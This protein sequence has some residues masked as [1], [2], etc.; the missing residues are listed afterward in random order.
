MH[1]GNGDRLNDAWLACFVARWICALCEGTRWRSARSQCLVCLARLQLTGSRPY[2]CFGYCT[3]VT[4]LLT[5]CCFYGPAHV[6][7]FAGIMTHSV[8]CGL[9]TFL[10]TLEM[11]CESFGDPDVVRLLRVLSAQLD[12]SVF[13][14]I[15]L[16]WCFFV[17]CRLD[18]RENNRC[19]FDCRILK[20]RHFYGSSFSA[21]RWCVGSVI[22]CE[23]L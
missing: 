8:A 20:R 7:S 21:C 15:S 23:Q 1:F 18:S 16:S 13:V 19:Y 11:L 17:T 22:S 4:T 2:H 12:V 3:T 5:C 14:V 9:C 6:S 10:W